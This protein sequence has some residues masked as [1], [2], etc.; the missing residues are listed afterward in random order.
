MAKI[1]FLE[2]ISPRISV[3]KRLI[4]KISMIQSLSLDARLYAFV[5]L[6]KVLKDVSVA[7]PAWETGLQP[8]YQALPE[9]LHTATFY[10][11][12]FT[13]SSI[14]TALGAWG[15]ALTEDSLSTW[16][17]PYES[18]IKSSSS[19]RI[20]VIMAGNIP[21]VGF[22]D[23]LCVLMAGHCFVGKLSS[24]D[25]ILLPAIAD[26]L[27]KIEPGFESMIQFTESTLHD[28]DAIIATGSNNTARYFEYYF[29]KY[30]HIIRKNRNGVAVLTGNETE[31]QLKKLGLDI[32]TYFGLGC[33]SV[34][35]VF[36]PKG[37]APEKLFVA[38]EPFIDVLGNHNKYM[39][40]YSYNHSVFLLNATPHLDN[41]VFILTESE[42]YS[43]PIPVLYYQFYDDLLSLQEKLNLDDELIQ[44]IA[45][46]AF[47][48]D[49]TVLLGETQNPGLADYADGVDTMKFLNDL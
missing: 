46:D 45:N 26:V 32:C 48:T 16:I 8:A 47:T 15:K 5:K 4:T 2:V 20:A 40:N 41:G 3:T 29:S 9:A 34:S 17:S 1:G 12:W 39:N 28:F 23:F 38:I 27:C 6:G 44:C 21:L 10:N 42:Q 11:A 24:S 31:D 18:G 33:R 35:K 49:K 22:H 25:K 37:F 43:S 14:A 30:P 19:K 7:F 13:P 36:L